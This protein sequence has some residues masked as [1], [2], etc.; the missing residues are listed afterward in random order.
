MQGLPPRT[1]FPANAGLAQLDTLCHES[2]IRGKN[3]SLF[4]LKINLIFSSQA[5]LAIWRQRQMGEMGVF[6]GITDPIQSSL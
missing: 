4:V 3:Q 1:P 2:R 5:I 6:L